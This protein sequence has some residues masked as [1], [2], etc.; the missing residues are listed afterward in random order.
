MNKFIVITLILFATQGAFA[1]GPLK[2]LIKKADTLLLKRYNVIDYDTTYINRSPGK[3]GL[4]AWGTLSGTSLRARGNGDK[5][6]LTTDARTTISLEFD[7]YD[8]ALEIST[9]PR[10]FT[11]KN[12]DFELN[13]NFYPRRFVLDV[14]YQKAE[15]GAGYIDYQG[16]HIDV[17][18]GWLKSQMLHIDFYYTFNYKKFS[19]DAPFYQ[20]Y[21]QKRSAG[22][23][24]AGISYLG[25]TIRTTGEMPS[26]YP[27][28]YIKAQHVGV[29]GGYAY[30]FVASK[31]WLLHI[32]FVPSI[33]VWQNNSVELNGSSVKSNTKFP[34]IEL[35][36]RTGVVYYFNPRH[37]IGAYAIGNALIKRKSYAEIMEDKWIARIFYGMRI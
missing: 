6:H 1:E 4:K 36:G 2:K 17:E 13:F 21:M 11:G 26:G 18:K 7:Y 37:F 3:I 27:T 30:N 23:W 25:G 10:T 15:S 9:T 22:S 35:N 14:N 31:H 29:G 16:R 33:I 24:L 34:T 8:L 28:A 19:Y 20:F 12:S 5:A 32:S